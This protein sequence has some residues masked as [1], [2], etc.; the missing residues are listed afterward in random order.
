MGSAPSPVYPG[1]MAGPTTLLVI[2]LLG[3]V[4]VEAKQCYN[5]GYRIIGDGEPEQLPELPFC[6]YF[7]TPTDNIA[8]CGHSDDCCAVLKE[9]TIKVDE[10][11]RE[12]STVVEGRHGCAQD[13]DHLAQYSVTFNKGALKPMSILREQ[14][15][16]CFEVD[17]D[18]LEDRGNLTLTRVEICLCEAEKC[19]DD[20]PIPE[21]PSGG[22]GTTTPS[23]PSK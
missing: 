16:S 1:T 4:S 13:L 5:C 22:T 15:H 3:Q 17:L 10:V 8:E 9:Y 6:G 20:D 12:N 11:T 23:G 21:V 7:A 18:S 19:N 14:G 2:A